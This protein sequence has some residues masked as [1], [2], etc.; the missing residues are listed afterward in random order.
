MTPH[1]LNRNAEALIA[2]LFHHFRFPLGDL[3]GPT[4][5]LRKVGSCPETYRDSAACFY[6]P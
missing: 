5:N 2:Q 3:C 6:D 1:L 4:F